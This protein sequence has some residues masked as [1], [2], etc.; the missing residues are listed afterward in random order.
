M[1][2]TPNPIIAAVAFLCATSVSVHATQYVHIT[3]ETAA[4]TSAVINS[5]GSLTES[6]VNFACIYKPTPQ[7]TWVRTPWISPSQAYVGS[8]AIGMEIDP[9]ASYLSTDVDKVNHR[10]SSGNDTF[11][12][13]F[14]IKRYTGFA[15]KLPSANFQIPEAGRKLM[16]AQWW[17]GAPYGP[18]V[19][20]EITNA[21][22]ST[23]TFRV[24]LLNNDTLGNPSAIP[25]DVGGGTIPFDTWTTFVVMLIP[26]YTGSGQIKVWLNGTQIVSWVGKV[27][28]D[29]ATKPY[30][31]DT[32]GIA[33]PNLKFD[34]FYGPY[35]DRQNRKHQVFFDEVK[36]A[37]TYAEA[38]P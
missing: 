28:Y 26:D 38:A 22:T 30:T 20:F 6:G 14:G 7:A 3:A 29:P 37:D 31:G 32:S 4:P 17:Q 19:R 18:P 1:K 33:Y 35:R 24:W 23:V 15:L 2:T 25:I 13:G 12:L 27:G 36:F 16:L 5:D 34:V 8:H 11:A 21:T 9:V 10:I